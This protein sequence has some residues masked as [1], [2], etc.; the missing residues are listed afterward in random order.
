MSASRVTT[1]PPTIADVRADAA[2][3]SVE[4]DTTAPP[5]TPPSPDLVPSFVG[6]FKRLSPSVVNIYTQEVVARTLPSPWGP[7]SP[8]QSVGT[9]LGSGM[10]LDLEGHILTNAHVVENAAEIRV[11]FSD[12]SELPARLVGLDPVRDLAVLK[13]D[14]D[15]PARRAR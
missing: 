1:I 14:G 2:I 11:R 6:L 5:R 10:A 4:P 7:V 12:E 8:D 3:A 9:S 15:D 13:V